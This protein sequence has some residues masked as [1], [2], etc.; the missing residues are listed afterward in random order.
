[1]WFNVSFGKLLMPEIIFS[2]LATSELDYVLF[3][4]VRFEFRVCRSYWL[5]AYGTSARGLCALR[6]CAG[7][8]GTHGGDREQQA[9]RAARWLSRTSRRAAATR[10][11]LAAGVMRHGSRDPLPGCRSSFS[12]RPGKE[13]AR[14]INTSCVARGAGVPYPFWDQC[15]HVPNILRCGDVGGVSTIIGF[16]SISLIKTWSWL[17][18]KMHFGR[19]Q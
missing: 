14:V 11:G 15:D 13:T 7:E 3:S 2:V 10:V 8:A 6:L 19:G 1:M 4:C 12:R 9:P 16:W 18:F 17:E 5:G